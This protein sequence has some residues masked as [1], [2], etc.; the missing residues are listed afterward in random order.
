MFFKKIS[1]LLFFYIVFGIAAAYAGTALSFGGGDGNSGKPTIVTADT[2]DMDLVNK[3]IIL[4]GNVVVNDGSSKIDADRIDIYLKKDKEKSESG[5]KGKKENSGGLASEAGGQQVE[6]IIATGHVVIERIGVDADGKP[7][8]TQKA[9][10][11][12]AVYEP[13]K[14]TMVLTKKPMLIYGN[15]SYI[16][17]TKITLWRDSDRLKVEGNRS[18]GRTS[19]LILTPKDQQELDKSGGGF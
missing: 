13:A 1:A 18:V 15:G 10:G 4:E 11:G 14:G 8:P 9:I 12:K 7:I 16:E 17:G 19:R 2:M 3:I 5:G 6:K